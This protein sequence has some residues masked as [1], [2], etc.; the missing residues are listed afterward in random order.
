VIP[1][2]S[3]IL[4]MF[5]TFVVRMGKSICKLQDFIRLN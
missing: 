4:G 5:L 3:A 1:V 2:I